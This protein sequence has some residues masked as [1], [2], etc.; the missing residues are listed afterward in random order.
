MTPPFVLRT[1]VVIF[2]NKFC[3][4][5]PPVSIVLEKSFYHLIKRSIARMEECMSLGLLKRVQAMVL[6]MAQALQ[7][8]L[9][10]HRKK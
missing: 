4:I 3:C 9:Q 6:V 10:G 7:T 1:L 8:M 2:P 5:F